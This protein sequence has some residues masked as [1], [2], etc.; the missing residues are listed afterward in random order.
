M[1][2]SA[3]RCKDSF[4]ASRGESKPWPSKIHGTVMMSVTPP[5][6]RV[7][8]SRTNRTGRRTRPGSRTEGRCGRIRRAA[9]QPVDH[10]DQVVEL[11]H[12]GRPAVTDARRATQ[13]HVGVTA[14]VERHGL[15]RCRTHLQPGEVEELAWCSTMPPPRISLMTSIISST[16]LPRF[17]YGAPHHSN[18][19]GAQPI[20]TPKPNRLPVSSRPTPPAGPAAPDSGNPV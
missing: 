9:P 4:F 17:A 8:R 19:S 7:R 18:S 12:R 14:D 5:R 11:D 20:P 16:R 6:R 10:G 2:L 15:A 13:R 3:K 1:Y